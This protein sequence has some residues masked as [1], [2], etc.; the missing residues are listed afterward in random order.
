MLL[1]LSCNRSWS[2]TESSDFLNKCQ[3][4]KPIGID[5]QE[6]NDFCLC[7]KRASQKKNLSYQSFLNADLAESDLNDII[8]SCSDE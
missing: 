7:L 2:D 4:E 5:A 3:Q 8:S 6:Y 1:A